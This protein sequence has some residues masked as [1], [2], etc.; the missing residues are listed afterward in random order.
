MEYVI[1]LVDSMAKDH[2]T[3]GTSK[4]AYIDP[5]RSCTASM[6]EHC[7]SHH[8]SLLEG[9]HAHKPM[10]DEMVYRLNLLDHGHLG[11]RMAQHQGFFVEALANDP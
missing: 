11:Q 3:I 8:Q 4:R 2:T 7:Q 9:L 6:L 10:I 5:S 1:Q